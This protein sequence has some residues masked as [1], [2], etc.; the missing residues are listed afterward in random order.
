MKDESDQWG[1]GTNYAMLVSARGASDN[2][3]ISMLG[4]H[5]SGLAVR[6]G[7]VSATTTLGRTICSVACI[8]TEE[9]TITLPE[10]QVYDDGHVVKI[11]NLNGKKVN[12]KPGYS[13]HRE[14]NSTSM[15]YD[16]I[17]KESYIHSDQG[18]HYTNSSPDD[19]LQL[20][21]AAEYVF[22]GT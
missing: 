14:W 11:K 10:M 6:T 2:V 13:Y 19:C 3:A 22:I 21:D 7:A 9:I 8:N 1:F 17:K 20:A 15:T 18:S 5:I 4:G 16:E 12:I